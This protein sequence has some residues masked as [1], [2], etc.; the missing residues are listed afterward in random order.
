MS[1]QGVRLLCVAA[2]MGIPWRPAVN[3]AEPEESSVAPAPQGI[4][5]PADSMF[6]P[7]DFKSLGRLAVPAG[8]TV[9][10]HTGDEGAPDGPDYP[11]EWMI[12]GSFPNNNAKELLSFPYVDEKALSPWTVKAAGAAKWWRWA[13]GRYGSLDLIMIPFSQ[14]A[15]CA[16][17]AFTRVHAAE[18]CEA[19]F[20]LGWDD[21]IAVWL[22]GKEVWRSETAG[23]NQ[24]KM[25]LRDV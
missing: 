8:A 12:L 21:G 3:A 16:A 24:M 13:P 20:L 22:A 23:G 7:G 19:T 10:F 25:R 6:R 15:N 4:S 9:T 5:A 2:V 1:K 11:P 14:K 18:D 17:Y